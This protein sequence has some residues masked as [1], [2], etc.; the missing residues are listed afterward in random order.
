MSDAD[1]TPLRVTQV[2]YGRDIDLAIREWARANGHPISDCGRVGHGLV[3]AFFAANPDVY[4]R[5]E[6]TEAVHAAARMPGASPEDYAWQD[7]GPLGPIYTI[8]LVRGV[9]E[10]EVLRRLG[11]APEHIRLIDVDEYPDS[12]RT[13][14]VT[15][16]RAGD[17]TIVIEEC[18]WLGVQREVIGKLSRD[19]EEAVAVMRHDYAARHDFAYALDGELVTGFDP[20]QPGTRWG[21]APDRLNRH[22]RQLGIDPATDDWIDNAIQAVLALAGRISGVVVTPAHIERPVLGAAFF[23]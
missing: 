1:F 12:S 3:E 22:L 16:R 15:V 7:E 23:R 17:W 6:K 4:E 19:G 13:E 5:A 10:Y 18:G 9:E 14:I 11:A 21:T 2:A 20:S 8:T